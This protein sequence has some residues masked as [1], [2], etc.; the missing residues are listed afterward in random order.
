MNNKLILILLLLLGGSVAGVGGFGNPQ[1]LGGLTSTD[2]DTSSELS[3]ILTDETGSGAACFAT[4]PT[5]T[6]KISVGATDP[7][8]AATGI[9]MQNAEKICTEAAPAAGDVCF[10]I[11]ASEIFSIDAAASAVSLSG[12]PLCFDTTTSACEAWITGAAGTTLTLLAGGTTVLTLSGT[13]AKFDLPPTSTTDNTTDLGTSANS[14][15]NLYLDG[16]KISPI[17][18]VT[19]TDSLVAADCGRLTTVT[20]GTAYTITLPEASTVLGCPYTLSYIGADGLGGNLLDITPLDSDADGIEGTCGAV[21]FTGTADADIG[22]T[23]ATGLTGDSITIW[24]CSAAM[25]CVSACTGI[26]ANN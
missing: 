18:T 5:F 24:A 12:N 26:W 17:N 11:D 10:G 22:L 3:T 19:G 15:R 23:A 8:D 6:T 2:L 9:N 7:A 1:S 20:T 14:F 16:G 13:Q 21:T 4:N 25:W